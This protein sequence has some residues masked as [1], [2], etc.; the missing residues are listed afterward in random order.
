MRRVVSRALGFRCDGDLVDQALLGGLKVP[1]ASGG[2]EGC[3]GKR[4]GRRK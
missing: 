4:K 3:L 2:G 1:A